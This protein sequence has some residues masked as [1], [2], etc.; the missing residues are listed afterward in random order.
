MNSSLHLLFPL[1]SSVLFVVAALFAKRATILGAGPITATI[2]SNFCLAT[3]WLCVGLAR[4]DWLPWSGIVP[5]LFIAVAFLVG[6]LC[7]FLAFR[8]GDVSL[9]TPVFGVKIIMVAVISACTSNAG[10]GVRI[11]IAAALAT[12]GVIVIQAGASSPSSNKLSLRRATLAIGLALL[13]AFALS[14]FDVGVQHYGPHFGAIRFLTTMFSIVGLMTFLL[15]PW[16]DSPSDLL[17]NRALVPLALAALF[18]TIQAISIT[19]SLAQFGDATRINIVYSLRG[20]WSVLLAWMLSRWAIS[21]E[22]HP[23]NRMFFIRLC[24]AI[25]LLSA[26]VVALA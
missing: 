2:F 21:P 12:I 26:V 24:G 11:W 19:Y 23:S 15:L 16:V 18:M 6:Q 3:C 4:N 20:L 13:A 22:S 5:A 8:L 10:I 25:L 9:A 17:R 7:T 14:L 1:F